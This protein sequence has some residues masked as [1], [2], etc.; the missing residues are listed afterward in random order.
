MAARVLLQCRVLMK[1]LHPTG[2]AAV[3]SCVTSVSLPGRRSTCRAHALCTVGLQ[4]VP[5]PAGGPAAYLHAAEAG[6]PAWHLLQPLKQLTLQPAHRHRQH[7]LGPK[8]AAQPWQRGAGH[9]GPCVLP[10]TAPTSGL[11]PTPRCGVC[12]VHGVRAVTGTASGCQQ[13]GCCRM[14]NACCRAL[15]PWW[16]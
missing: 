6:V 9:C 7:C 16:M 4:W 14:L 15:S 13:C 3:T 11:H 5:M 12:G 8:D 1:S 10:G 2:L